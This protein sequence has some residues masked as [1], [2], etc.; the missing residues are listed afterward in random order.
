MR[1]SAPDTPLLHVVREKMKRI[2]FYEKTTLG[3]ICGDMC[4]DRIFCDNR[5]SRRLYYP[6]RRCRTNVGNGN[7]VR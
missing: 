4:N 1:S 2:E 5:H 3:N 7:S 6:K